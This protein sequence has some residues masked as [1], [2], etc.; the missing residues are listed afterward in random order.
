MLR[1]DVREFD[2][3]ILEETLLLDRGDL[4]R[5]ASG[6][7]VD[8]KEKDLRASAGIGRRRDLVGERSDDL[9]IIG[10]MSKAADRIGIADRLADAHIV[11]CLSVIAADQTC[12]SRL[13][14][15]PAYAIDRARMLPIDDEETVEPL[16]SN[17]VTSE[18]R[19]PIA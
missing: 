5:R 8:R 10:H 12:D 1:P 16:Q 19:L 9:A 7:N 11:P 2:R 4:R 18:R 6:P 3:A 15:V 13:L 17:R 14:G